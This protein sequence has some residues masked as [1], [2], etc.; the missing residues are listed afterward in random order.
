MMTANLSPQKIHSDSA[1][2]ND[3]DPFGRAAFAAQLAQ[4]LQL[5]PQQESVVLGLEGE[6]GGGKTW[7]I[8]RIRQV[9]AA[10][11]KP[12]VVINF[13]PWLIGSENE[14]IAAFM[15]ELAAQIMEH[16]SGF[17]AYL[18]KA[19]KLAA[20]VAAYGEKLTYLKYLK[21][22]PGISGIGQ[23]VEDHEK[24]I[25]EG[26]QKLQ[27][28]LSENKPSLSSARKAIEVALKEF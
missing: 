6:W 19:K 18:Q 12:P 22:V 24:I 28:A 17:P 8:E 13:N 25:K 16:A 11:E 1:S 14:L 23:F 20:S 26:A 2:E 7:V 5:A 9:L 10:Q 4:Y 15:D 27:T 3:D 21:Y